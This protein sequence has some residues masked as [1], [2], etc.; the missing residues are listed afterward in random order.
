V[1]RSDDS[2]F[3][4]KAAFVF[5][6]MS[7]ISGRHPGGSFERVYSFFLFKAVL[8]FESRASHL[9]DRC[10][11]TQATSKLLSVLVHFFHLNGLS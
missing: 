2:R 1:V 3:P 5:L 9:L 4:A 8:G 10:S 7:Q 6:F 11:T